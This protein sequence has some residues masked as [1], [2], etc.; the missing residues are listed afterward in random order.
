MT[1]DIDFENFLTVLKRMLVVKKKES[2][3]VEQYE[4]DNIKIKWV[5]DKFKPKFRQ[6]PKDPLMDF[7]EKY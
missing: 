2:R 1:L 3:P 7:S 5:G 4:V 6:K